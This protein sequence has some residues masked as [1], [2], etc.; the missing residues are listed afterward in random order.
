MPGRKR[1]HVLQ[2][3]AVLLEGYGV[4]MKLVEVQGKSSSDLEHV[5]IGGAAARRGSTR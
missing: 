3:N 1:A 4:Q 5:R 2:S